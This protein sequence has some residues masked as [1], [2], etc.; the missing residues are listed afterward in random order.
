MPSLMG[1][2]PVL[3]IFTSIL[4]AT[5]I[6]LLG[7]NPVLIGGTASATVPFIA[8]AVQNQG[9]GG[10][11]KVSVVASVIMMGVCVIRLGRYVSRVPHAVV[12]GVSCGMGA[13]IL[14]SQLDAI[15]G[16][17]CA[18]TRGARSYRAGLGLEGQ[19]PD[20]VG[21]GGAFPRTS[22]SDDAVRCRCR[23]GRLR[24]RQ[25][26]RRHVRR[27]AQRGHS[28]AQSG[29]GPLRWHHT[30]LKFVACGVSGG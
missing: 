19:Q 25:C 21:G 18:A 16:V 11:A 9:V 6:T 22:S 10:A 26:V 27:S 1:L 28:G 8:M 29:S 12:T 7:R 20:A 24:N 30:A 5:L 14:V 17:D 3:G 15:L 2:R 4:T 13:G 23:T